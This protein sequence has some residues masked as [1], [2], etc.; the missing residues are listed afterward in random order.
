ML[1]SQPGR[2]RSPS[3]RHQPYLRRMH[4]ARAIAIDD[5]DDLPRMSVKGLANQ[6]CHAG[7]RDSVHG[8]ELVFGLPCRRV[9]DSGS[10]CTRKRALWE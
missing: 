1:I 3:L 10:G 5:G 7:E 9:C 4:P 2:W 8:D 6:P